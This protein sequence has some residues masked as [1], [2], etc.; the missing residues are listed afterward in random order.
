MRKKTQIPGQRPWAGYLKIIL[1]FSLV[2][3]LRGTVLVQENE[4]LRPP[5]TPEELSM[6]DLPEYPGAPAV[7]LY[8]ERTED[9]EKKLISV[10]K[11][12]KVLTPAGRDFANLEIFY[13][14]TLNEVKDI[15][16]TV[17]ETDGRIR[18]VKPE[19][20][21]K[22]A[23]KRGE[24]EY[25]V[26]TLAIPDISPGQIID[27]EYQIVRKKDSD[28][29]IAII[30][31]AIVIR[32]AFIMA[33]SR[34][35]YS[36]LAVDWDLQDSLYVR[37]AKYRFVA[38]PSAGVRTGGKYKMVWVANRLKSAKPK[39]DDKGLELEI[40]DIPPFD[41]EEFMPPESNAK[42]TFKIF[43]L[44][45]T[46]KNDNEYWEKAASS[47]RE[48]AGEFMKGEKAL[49]REVKAIIGAETDPEIKLR[50]I[51]E[52]VRKI[53]NLDYAFEMT[54]KERKKI[55]ENNKVTDVLKNN[56]GH[57]V[58]IVKTFAALAE[59]A[60]YE[61]Y[62]VR[63]VSRDDKLFNPNL[64]LFFT[65][66]DSEIVMVKV[67]NRHEAFDPGTP[68]CPYGLVY[69]PKTNTAALTFENDKM[70]MFTSPMLSPENA[71]ARKKAELTVDG[72]ANLTGSLVLT[73]QGQETLVRKLSYR[74]KDEIKIKEELEEELKKTLPPGSR[75][76]L[77]NIKGMDENADGLTV[78]YEVFIA[79]AINQMG[80]RLL[81]PA[82]VLSNPGL[83]PFRSIYRR[84]PIYF[85]YPYLVS[86][87]IMITLPEG[88]D[89]DAVPGG[90]EKDS[91]R[92]SFF[93]RCS[94][95]QPDKLRI[96]RQISVKKSIFPISDYVHLKEFFDFI[97]AADEQ[98]ILL[99]T[100]K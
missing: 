20:M 14:S 59:A 89:I 15:K 3:Y 47:W 66:F 95:E 60:G 28:D 25:R 29:Y 48:S 38:D 46:I 57:A 87:E 8:F 5:V 19:I 65:Q 4:R 62:L 30:G 63:V 73:Y 10:F 77:K 54:E 39:I 97:R 9:R 26:K 93:L 2:F 31:G 45:P 13:Y 23:S 70:M 35:L 43:Y 64:P 56:Y 74:D 33:L 34:D 36:T 80:D 58:Q 6:T 86:D 18:E 84:Y 92:A 37:K 41:K 24:S 7:C 42:I 91:A 85:E 78:D 72:Q 94:V 49:A 11:R 90:K 96:Q 71:V 17:Y 51:Y 27:Y 55:K 82:N 67:G 68:G 21:E 100:R 75:V 16:V 83:Y 69:W 50:L 81:L 99:K 61:T 88:Y 1:I 22:T 53:R 40:N 52:R 44:D 32:V 98:Q 79:G 76:T 12:I